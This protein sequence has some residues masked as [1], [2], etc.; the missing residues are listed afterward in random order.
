MGKTLF[1]TVLLLIGAVVAASACTMGFRV[2]TSESAR[3]LSIRETPQIVQATVVTLTDGQPIVLDKWLATQRRVTIVSFIYTRCNTLCSVLGNEFQQLQAQI[4]QRHLQDR[5]QLL[6]ISFDPKGDTSDRLRQYASS[7]GANPA[8]WQFARVE[9][10]DELQQ[11]LRAF[12]IV[13][14]P[15]RQGGYVHNAALHLVNPQA[16]LVDIEDLDAVAQ[17]LANAEV[18]R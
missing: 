18:V 14:I 7:M 15:D 16:R 5:V 9:S 12:G 1:V 11:L 2:W 8:I 10:P 6:S 4:I 17:T 3:R 13:V